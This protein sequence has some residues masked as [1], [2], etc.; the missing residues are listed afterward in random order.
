MNGSAIDEMLER[1]VGPKGL[2]GVAA[3]LYGCAVLRAFFW[4][5]PRR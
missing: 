1:A 2:P 3:T 4:F 5:F